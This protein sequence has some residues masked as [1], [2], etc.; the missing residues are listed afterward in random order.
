M[1]FNYNEQKNN[2]LNTERNISFDD[3]TDAILGGGLLDILDHPNQEQYAH[4]KLFVVEIEN[5]AYVVP[6]VREKNG[7]FFL[8]TIYADRK[9]TK[10]YIK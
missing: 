3:V 9:M 10:K 4:Q 5:Y 1:K 2:K 8:K 7:D 6:F